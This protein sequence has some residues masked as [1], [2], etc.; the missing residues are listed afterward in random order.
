M[1]YSK[2]HFPLVIPAIGLFHTASGLEWMEM[3][4]HGHSLDFQRK[5]LVDGVNSFFPPALSDVLMT[6]V[7]FN[8]LTSG[9]SYFC[10]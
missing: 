8:F 1:C 5:Q 2:L 3:A 7:L 10:Q 6:K 9:F 4:T